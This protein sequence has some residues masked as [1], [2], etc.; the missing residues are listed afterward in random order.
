MDRQNG[1]GTLQ[2]DQDTSPQHMSKP[3]SPIDG[4]L[5]K[6]VV[7][8]DTRSDCFILIPA[9]NLSTKTAHLSPAP[10]TNGIKRVC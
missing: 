1:Q 9:N 6:C 8:I 5:P 10:T 4:F 3:S 2:Q 7:A